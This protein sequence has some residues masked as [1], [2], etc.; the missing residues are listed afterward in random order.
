MHSNKNAQ[1]GFTLIELLVVIAIIGMLSSIVLASLNSARLKARDTR[2][3]ADMEQ[4]Q[5]ALALYYD[6]NAAYP[7]SSLSGSGCWGVWESGNVTGGGSFLPELV[8]GGFIPTIPKETKLTGC[9]YRYMKFNTASTACGSA[10]NY[11]ILTMTLESAAPSSCRNTCVNAWG[12]GE[13]SDPNVCLYVL[14]E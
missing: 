9:V 3:F 4:L 1:S 13:L 5:T 10:G 12:W 2:R 11:A 8:T 6:T 7:P 14:K